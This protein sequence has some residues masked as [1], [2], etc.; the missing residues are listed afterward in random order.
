MYKGLHVRFHNVDFRLFDEAKMRLGDDKCCR[1]ETNN[2]LLF[3]LFKSTIYFQSV[4][5]IAFIFILYK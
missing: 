5:K 4:C 3:H 1:F 2:S